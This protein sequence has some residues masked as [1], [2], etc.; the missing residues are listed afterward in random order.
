MITNSFHGCAFAITM[1]TPFVAL[2]IGGSRLWRA[3]NTR[4]YQLFELFGLQNRLVD[5]LAD[6]QAQMNTPI[7]WDKINAKLKE[8]RN[9]GV[10][11][12]DRE[13]KVFMQ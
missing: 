3:T 1:N 12:L 10:E 13:L 9:V 2:K 4:F 5:N 6:L 11:F 7:E 8:W